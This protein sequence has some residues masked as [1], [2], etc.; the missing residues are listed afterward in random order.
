MKQQKYTAAENALKQALAINI[1]N[2]DSYFYLGKLSAMQ[3][4]TEVACE[5]FRKSLVFG[6]EGPLH[7]EAVKFMNDSCGGWDE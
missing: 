3:E 7:E 5:N 4:N 6:L 2:P 1:L